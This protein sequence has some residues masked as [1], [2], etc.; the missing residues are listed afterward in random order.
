MD[1]KCPNC[2]FEL[3]ETI[4][5]EL[6]KEIEKQYADREIKKFEALTKE[7]EQKEIENLNLKKK[8]NEKEELIAKRLEQKVKEER[9]T[10]EKAFADEIHKKNKNISETNT[11]NLLLEN[12]LKE[13]EV[14]K[15]DAVDQAKA[16]AIQ[17]VRSKIET[18]NLLKLQE[19]DNEIDGLKNSIKELESKATQGSQQAQGE[20][21][22]VFIEET[23][24]KKFPLDRVSEVKK[25]VNGTDV[26]FSIINKRENELGI[27]SIESKNAKKFSSSWVN[28]LK[29]DMLNGK[30]E[31]GLLVTLDLP[32]NPQEF[33]GEGLYICG[34]HQ[35]E[36]YCKLLRDALYLKHRMQVKETHRSDKA[37]LMYDYIT[38]AE[39]GQKMR[40][41]SNLISDERDLLFKEKRFMEQSFAKREKL[42]SKKET[43]F[44]VIRGDFVGIGGEQDMIEHEEIALVDD[45]NRND[46]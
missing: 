41:I 8:V 3:S 42:L 31:Y 35:F 2:G 15:R 29:Q 12:R 26:L 7:N 14:E 9:E 13:F 39:F 45:E 38:S 23:L 28:K 10:W 4:K 24:R 33:E 30:A 11:K 37:N 43:S 44:S 20:V 5:S 27:I 16:L 25:G 17:E 21:G 40:Q 19:K 32:E 22:E 46:T 34:F 6:R 1:D 36:F 18:E